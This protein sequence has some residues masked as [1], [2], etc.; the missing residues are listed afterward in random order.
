MSAL[1]GP[2]APAG[3]WAGRALGERTVSWTE[4]QAILYALAVGA[5][6]DEL[7]LVY[8]RRLRVLPTFG[9]TL[10]QWAPD[11]LGGHGAFDQSTALHGAQG[12]KVAAPL[13]TSGELTLAARVAAVWDKGAAAVF[14]VEVESRFFTATW[15]IFAPGRGGF[16]GERGPSARRAEPDDAPA[17][18]FDIPTFAEQAALYR[19]CGDLHALH[20]DP[21][22]AKTA[23]LDR[24]ILHG[25]ATMAAS[26]VGLGRALGAHPADLAEAHVRFTAPVVP[27]DVLAVR[28]RPTGRAA[29]FDV[30]VD[31]RTVLGGCSV[32]FG[33]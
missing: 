27:G 24:P 1:P 6:A 5:R 12:L 25:L 19:L 20:I 2:D 15:S 32:G 30:T 23:G 10:A 13:P 17:L 33:G 28:A 3:E 22:A 14:D 29:D 4:S 16:G 26:A 11:V 7:D 18:A 21:E 9:L 31:G 8:E